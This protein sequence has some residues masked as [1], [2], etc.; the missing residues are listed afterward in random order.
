[1]SETGNTTVCLPQLSSEEVRKRMKK[2]REQWRRRDTEKEI[3]KYKYIRGHIQF[4]RFVC[5]L[6]I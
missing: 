5:D 1:M 6:Y 4:E 3:I 2:R